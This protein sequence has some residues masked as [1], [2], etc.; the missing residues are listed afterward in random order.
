[1]INSVKKIKQDN[2]KKIKQDNVR[3]NDGDQGQGKREGVYFILVARE[4]LSMEVALEL[5]LA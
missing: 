2:V 4:D 3:N 5:T 1:M